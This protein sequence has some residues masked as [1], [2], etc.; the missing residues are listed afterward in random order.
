MRLFYYHAEHGNFGDDLNGW[1]WQRLLPGAWDEPSDVAMLGIGTILGPHWPRMRKYVV[2]SSGIGYLPPPPGFGGDAW[3]VVGVRGPLSAEVLGLSPDKVMGDGALLVRLL[4]EYDPL[5][6]DK[7]HGVVFMPHH[8]AVT[9]G[10]WP[11]VCRRA[12][13][14][15]LSPQNDSQQTLQRLRSARLVLADAMHAA[16]AADALRVP[17]VPVVTSN[18]IN[19]F[20]WR[21]WTRSHDLP[22]TPTRLPPSTPYEELRSRT[23]SLRGENFARPASERDALEMLRHAGDLLNIGH[24]PCLRSMGS[25]VSGRKVK[26]LMT[27]MGLVRNERYLDTAAAALVRLAQSPG[28]LSADSVHARMLDIQAT[29][30][31]ELRQVAAV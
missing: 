4:P 23:A 3:H 2:M 13:V 17:W 10:N 5:P 31:D 15:F 1:L 28:T 19:A 21:D 29:K 27:R 14:E 25:H 30:L 9:Y 22:Y 16:V 24:W 12:G 11:E 6:A 20:K 18:E 8:K 7:R 26:E